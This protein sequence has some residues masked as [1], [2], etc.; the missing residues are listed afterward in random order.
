[1]ILARSLGAVA[2]A[3]LLSLAFQPA[4]GLP[5]RGRWAVG[6]IVAVV[7]AATPWLVPAAA[8][9]PRLAVAIY[10]GVTVL[11]LWDLHVG[12]ERGVRP[13]SRETMAFL[14][15]P[16]SLVHRRKE[17]LPRSRGWGDGVRIGAASLVAGGSYGLLRQLGAV[18]WSG[19]PFL[20]EHA[21][22]ATAFM[23]LAVAVFDF[24]AAS[25]RLLGGWSLDP[26]DRPWAAR[27][28]VEFWR[29]YNRSITEF[30]REDV[31]LPAGGRRRRV[32][33]V[34][35]TFLVS[36]LV[37][38][39]IFLA[40]TGAIHGYQTAFFLLQGCAVALTVR[41]RPPRLLGIA[42]T[43]AFNVVT[44]V[45]FFASLH[46]AVTFYSRGLPGWLW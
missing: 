21:A 8:P 7:V 25:A 5:R 6:S 44:S 14:A 28:P 38:E 10:A 40:V 17:R 11:K 27:T 45:L 15:I 18:D 23:V 9:V 12:A 43:W 16:T 31:F 13:G 32:A 34:L 26:V 46:R 39:Y 19:T 36:G 37:H 20:V 22:K 29:R 30:L 2:V 35:V 33:P 42:G 3:Y 4:L 1:M 41:I 24:L